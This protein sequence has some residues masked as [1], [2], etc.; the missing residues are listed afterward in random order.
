[1]C[2]SSQ[3]WAKYTTTNFYHMLA[4]CSMWSMQQQSVYPGNL[5]ESGVNPA[6]R[7]QDPAYVVA[8]VKLRPY[9]N[10]GGIWPLTRWEPGVNPADRGWTRP[11]L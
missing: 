8:H 10:F 1:M 7:G 11:K 4:L 6:D 2:C 3:F 9:T 5:V